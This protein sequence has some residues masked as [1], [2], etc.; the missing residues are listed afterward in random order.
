[1]T[2][3]ARSL[4]TILVSLSLL[5]CGSHADRYPVIK[6]QDGDSFLVLAGSRQQKVRIAAIDAP[7]YQQPYGQ[8]SKLSLKEL[9]SDRDVRLEV[10]KTDDY[11]RWVAKVWV[12]QLDC[13]ESSYT[14]CETNLDAG[15][16]QVQNGFAWWYRYWG[17]VRKEQSLADQQLYEHAENR[18]KQNKLGLWRDANPVNPRQW[19]KS[20][21]R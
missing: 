21:P 16:F 5:A 14:R 20:H 4:I 12:A 19:R 7:E 3:F 9:L 13:E 1:M 2:M 17:K 8:Q 6:V 15:L 11:G 10:I 18:A